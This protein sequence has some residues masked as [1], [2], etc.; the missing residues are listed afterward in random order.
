MT[1]PTR[2]KDEDEVASVQSQRST[3]HAPTLLV[4]GAIPGWQK[5]LLRA[6]GRKLL[7]ANLSTTRQTTGR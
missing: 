2:L 7:R 5:T 1:G 4:S 6:C 3:L